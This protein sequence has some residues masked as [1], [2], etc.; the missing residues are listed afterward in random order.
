VKENYKNILR[1]VLSV[2]VLSV[3][4]FFFYREFRENWVIIQS[5]KMKIGMFFLIASFL[6]I[7]ITYVLTT[8]CWF[9]TIN[10]LS[11]QKI[12]FMKSIA[13]VNTSNLTKYIPGKLWSYA[14]QM[15]WLVN[16]GFSKSLI[17]YVNLMNLFV[18]LITTLI[19]GVGCLVFSPAIFP[20]ALTIT[21]LV[22][23]I[24]FEFLFIAYNS[25]VFKRVIAVVNRIF[26][27]DIVY[28]EAPRSLLYYLHFINFLSSLCFGLG[29]Y[30]LCLGIGFEF[31][32]SNILL[33]MSSMMIADVIGFVAVIMPGGLGVRES[34]MY[35]ILNGGSILTLALILPIATRLVSMFVDIFLGTIGVVLL[36]RI[37]AAGK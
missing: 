1:I 13:M 24:V 21:L 15:Y 2:L 20:P 9:L 22:A 18:S 5:F 26:K 29:A 3:I 34:V 28:Y 23:L 31:D 12:T 33:I 27:L 4:F 19:V 32:S 36:K 30:F 17:L 14:L 8:Y 10:A 35:L 7:V 16:A 37:K 11:E 6:A 25:P